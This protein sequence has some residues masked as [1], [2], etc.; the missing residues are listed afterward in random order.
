MTVSDWMNVITGIAVIY[1]GWQQNRIFQQQNRILASQGGVTM[2][3]ETVFVFRLKR[4]WPTMGMVVIMLLVCFDIYDRHHSAPTIQSVDWQAWTNQ[5]LKVVEHQRF[6]GETV[7]LDGTEYDDCTFQDVQFK[8][9]GKAP[10]RFVDAHFPKDADGKAYIGIGS[11]NQL[12]KQVLGIQATVNAAFG[13]PP[14][15]F[16]R[17][18]ENK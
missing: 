10:V 17:P 3:P 5:K 9:L 15:V 8:Y 12:V 7:T 18:G 2:L 6:R 14:T 16:E 1:F 11:N 13:F 4:Y